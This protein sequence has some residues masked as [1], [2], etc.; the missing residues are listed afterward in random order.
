M[1]PRASWVRERSVS[2]R[3]DFM[4]VEGIRVLVLLLDVRAR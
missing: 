1:A 3:R 4:V 2:E